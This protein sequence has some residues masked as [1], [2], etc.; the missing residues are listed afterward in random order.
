MKMTG[1]LRFDGQVA[2][3]TGGA[4][5]IGKAIVMALAERGAKVVVNGNFRPSGVGPEAEVASEIRDLGGDAIGFNASV[6][7]DEAVRAMVAKAVDHYGRLDIV[8]NNAGTTST[9]HLV[10]DAP[11]EKF[12]EQ[13]DVHVKGSLR[14]TRAA[15]P[16]LIASGA[17][18]ILNTGSGTALGGPGPNGYDGAYPVAKAALYGVTRQMAGEGEKVGIKANLIMP[19]A[20]SPMTIGALTGTPLGTWIS[21]KAGAEKMAASVLFLL[22]RECPANGQF[23]SS[24]GGRVARIFFGQAPGYF[25]PDLTPEDV[26]DNWQA[27]FGEVDGDRIVGAVEVRSME[28]E[29]AVLQTH[30]GA[31]GA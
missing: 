10:Q 20:E 26:R 25:N 3:V 9:E 19:W 27:I 12:D 8:V 28:H 31:V 6:R 21:E 1:Q 4:S 2:L 7:D 17:G 15:W 16:H 22:H 14:V 13:I 24:C 5:G 18:R 23:I 29:F 11:S 30:L